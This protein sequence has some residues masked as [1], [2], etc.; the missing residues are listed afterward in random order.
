MFLSACTKTDAAESLDVSRPVVQKHLVVNGSYSPT[1]TYPAV[2]VADRK[3]QITAKI[4]GELKEVYVKPGDQ[5]VEGQSLALLG[6]KQGEYEVDTALNTTKSLYSSVENTRQNLVL[7]NIEAVNEMSG[8]LNTAQLDLKKTKDFLQDIENS[9]DQ[10]IVKAKSSLKKAEINHNLAK[11]N[12][13]N[14][15]KQS[16]SLKLGSENRI[17]LSSSSRDTLSTQIRSTQRINRD[18]EDQYEDAVSGAEQMY[19]SANNYL[20][21]LIESGADASLIREAE[22]NLMEAENDLRSSQAQYDNIISQNDA[23]ID[24]LK[25]QLVTLDTT[26]DSSL[27]QNTNDDISI[28]NNLDT[29]SHQVQLAQES[30]NEANEGLT[31]LMVE[32]TK[33]LN[34]AKNN[35]ILKEAELNNYRN[36]LGLTK[37]MG[38]VK[39]NEL[40]SKIKELDGEMSKYTSLDQKKVLIAPFS[41]VVSKQYLNEG[42][43][44]APGTAVFEIVDLS[45]MDVQ[46]YMPESSISTI[47]IGEKVQVKIDSFDRD[48]PAIVDEIEPSAG[49]YSKKVRVSGIIY[50]DSETSVIDN[51][52]AT[53]EVADLSGKTG[54]MV[55]LSSVIF[56]YKDALVYKIVDNKLVLSPIKIADTLE[57]KVL[58]SEGLQEGERIVLN[59]FKGL[60]NGMEVTVENE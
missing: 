28:K 24:S 1:S 27:I 30:Y 33:A 39:E 11:L 9:F 53:V 45:K 49:Q 15:I 32:R 17:D 37:K 20:N 52:F 12:Y 18:L 3:T 44:V 51:T 50:K 13:D 14:Y 46:W 8:R 16:E 26:V 38:E 55:P 29:L 35:I 48:I 23:T 31:L 21:D 47:Q 7:A 54:I 58:V 56:K 43:M 19:I 41:G 2:I 42:S 34:E 59:L 40:D 60:E 57:D 6:D 22:L 5:V 4:G 36:S 25:K 10:Q